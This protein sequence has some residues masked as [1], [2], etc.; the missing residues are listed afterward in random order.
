[1]NIIFELVAFAALLLLA[2]IVAT[3]GSSI[4]TYLKRKKMIDNDYEKQWEKEI[5][6]KKEQQ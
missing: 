2:Y 3:I 4:E 1:M 6:T 5:S